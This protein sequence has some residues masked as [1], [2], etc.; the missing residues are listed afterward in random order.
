MN[1][2]IPQVD[3]YF[4][5]PDPADLWLPGVVAVARPVTMDANVLVEGTA[6]S[7]PWVY[8]PVTFEIVEVLTGELAGDR[9]TA[10]VAGGTAN[11]RYHQGLFEFDKQAL[12]AGGLFVIS[13]SRY[14]YPGFSLGAKLDS[15][16][17]ITPADTL[18]PLQ[19]EDL[20]RG[21][22]ELG[23]GIEMKELRMRVTSTGGADA[24]AR[25]DSVVGED[26]D[27]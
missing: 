5:Y 24:V 17:A 15:A 12:K 13:V 2:T 20:E 14:D 6:A 18:R 11:G 23:D 1:A 7:E 16:Y 4:E 26:S 27:A 25:L 3:Y 22:S 10:A 21:K 9:I 8:T 19:F